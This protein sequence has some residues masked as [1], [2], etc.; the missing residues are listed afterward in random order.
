SIFEQYDAF[1][2]PT[3]PLPAPLATLS[4]NDFGHTD[5][6]GRYRGFDMTGIFNLVPQCPALSVPSGF[7]TQRL[8]TGIQIAAPGFGD[9]VVLRIGAAALGSSGKAPVPPV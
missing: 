8:P 1:V 2:C 5:G 9:E 7:T 6:N 3:T 4:D